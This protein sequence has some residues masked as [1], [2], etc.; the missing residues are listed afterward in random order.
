MVKSR[1]FDDVLVDLVH[2]E[3]REAGLFSSHSAY[4]CQRS[5]ES[6]GRKVFEQVVDKEEIVRV[7]FSRDVQSI[8]DFKAYFSTVPL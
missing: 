7:V 1:A 6:G 2:I 5:V 8:A 4:F 3:E